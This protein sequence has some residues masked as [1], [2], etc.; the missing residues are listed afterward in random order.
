MAYDHCVT[1]K[2]LCL[3]GMHCLTVHVCHDHCLAILKSSSRSTNTCLRLQVNFEAVPD[4]VAGRKVFLHRGQAYIH[5]TE[6]TSLVVG[7]FRCCCCPVVCAHLLP[8]Q[9]VPVYLCPQLVE[10]L[11]RMPVCPHAAA[12][13]DRYLWP[14]VRPRPLSVNTGSQSSNLEQCC[15]GPIEHFLQESSVVCTGG[16]VPEVDLPHCCRGE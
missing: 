16:H 4:L 15:T 13:H 5:R 7:H 6:V 8:L 12:T 11:Q 3:L 10:C 1:S 14:C 9:S 2:L